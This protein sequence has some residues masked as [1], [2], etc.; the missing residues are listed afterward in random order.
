MKLLVSV[1]F[2]AACTTGEDMPSAPDAAVEMT[3]GDAATC[4]PRACGEIPTPYQIAVTY[5]DDGT[6]SMSRDDYGKVQAYLDRS[7]LWAGCETH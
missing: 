6:V 1:L 5:N 7:Q 3:T 4:A 2:V